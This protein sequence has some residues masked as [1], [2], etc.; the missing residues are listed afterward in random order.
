VAVATAVA[1]STLVAA[2]AAVATFAAAERDQAGRFGAE[3][4]AGC[5]AATVRR[6]CCEIVVSPRA[7]N[8]SR[9]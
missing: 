8:P 1:W 7:G 4:D 3:G 2:W 9:S 5:C 6:P